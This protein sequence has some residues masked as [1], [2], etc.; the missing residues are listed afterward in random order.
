MPIFILCGIPGVGKTTLGDNIQRMFAKAGTNLYCLNRDAIRVN[1][2][3]LFRQAAMEKRDDFRNLIPRNFDTILT[4][5]CAT[6]MDHRV[7]GR[8]G[9]VFDACNTDL[10][11]LLFLLKLLGQH[12]CTSM[13]KIHLVFVGD[14]SSKCSHRVIDSDPSLYSEYDHE[15][16]SLDY[17]KDEHSKIPRKVLEAK[18]KQMEELIKPES[19]EILKNQKIASIYNF[20]ARPSAED[21]KLF[22][23]TF[24]EPEK[25]RSKRIY[26][27]KKHEKRVKD[28]C[29]S[30]MDEDFDSDNDEIGLE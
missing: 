30:D 12:W 6:K 24:V 19:I 17:F 25:K 14:P 7:Y 26:G 8:D 15:D 22:K 13:Q 4:A 2:L 20:P 29:G 28:L 5:S 18:R 11:E 21:I 9:V 1:M 10:T 23:K 16:D 27:P 3:N